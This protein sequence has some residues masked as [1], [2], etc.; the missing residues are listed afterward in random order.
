MP[1]E[2]QR[3]AQGLVDCLDQVPG[4]VEQLR[5]T[6]AWCRQQAA[7]VADLSGGDAAGRAAVLQLQAAAEACDRAAHYASLAPPK[8]RDWAVSLV[9]GTGA[10]DGPKVG[11]S[12]LPMKPAK[13]GH[14]NS[15][16]YRK[17]FRKAYPDIAASVVVHHAVEQ[18]AMRRYPGAHI[19]PQQMHSLENLRGV[20]KGDVNSRIHLSE[21]RRDWNRFYREN[22]TATQTQLLEQA[23]RMDR[24]YGTLFKPQRGIPT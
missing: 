16:D 22:P 10:T 11:S 12:P 15:L 5:R 7:F 13:F 20:P 18:Q 4:V 3:V 23:A 21:L 14:A 17:T 6:A 9:G 19:T 1:S 2:L 24:K 8:A